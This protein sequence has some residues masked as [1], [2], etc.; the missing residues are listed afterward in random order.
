MATCSFDI[1]EVWSRNAN[2]ASADN[3]STLSAIR[4]L[5]TGT[6]ALENAVYSVI[7]PESCAAILWRDAK[8]AEKAADAMKLTAQDLLPLGIVDEIIPEPSGG[9]HNDPDASAAALRAALE[10][11]L[12]DLSGLSSAQLLEGRAKRFRNLG[13]FEELA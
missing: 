1:F 9:A 2:L 4:G 10:R 12:T 5:F 11:H 3:R 8:E 13:V 7:S 6:V